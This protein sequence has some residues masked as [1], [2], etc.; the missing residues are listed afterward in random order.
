M[1]SRRSAG[2]GLRLAEPLD[3][4]FRPF[5]AQSCFLARR[6]AKLDKQ[7]A[8]RARAI[9]LYRAVL[10]SDVMISDLRGQRAHPIHTLLRRMFQEQR[11]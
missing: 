5:E 11:S 9:P 2:L 1:C 4:Q 6:L 7:I 8:A 3:E 10:E